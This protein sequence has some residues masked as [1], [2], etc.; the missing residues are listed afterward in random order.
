MIQDIIDTGLVQWGAVKVILGGDQPWTQRV[1]GVS[2]CPQVGSMF[3]EGIWSGQKK[4]WEGS[5]IPR[6]ME[7]DEAHYRAILLGRPFSQAVGC[8]TQRILKLPRAWVV[9]CI[10]HLTMAM[11]RS[12]GEF[13]DRKA[14]AVTPALRQDLQV[15]LSERR[16]GWSV[17]GAASPDREET[18]NFFEAWPRIARCLGIRPS[19]AKCKAITNLWDVLH[20]LY[21]TYQAPNP[22]NCAAVARDFWRHCTAGTASWY[23]LSLEHDVDAMLH[24][25]KPFRLAMFSGDIS[26]SINRFLKHGHNEHSNRGGGVLSGG[27]GGR[28][29]GSS[30]V[31][32][33]QGGQCASTVHDMAICIL[34]R[35]MGS[36][37]G[38]PVASAVLGQGCHGGEEALEPHAGFPRT[39]SSAS[40]TCPPRIRSGR[41]WDRYFVVRS[42]ADLG[43]R[44]SVDLGSTIR[45]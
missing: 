18:A 28:L 29:V 11:G 30:V 39:E 35:V 22:L 5:A 19:T 8:S 9:L 25:I 38:G 36:A 10:L 32:H 15:L 4:T 37:R 24:N 34:R 27:G 43:K 40:S 17:Y 44:S 31:R 26:E 14:R 1:I 2:T 20:A 33:P 45:R 41:S 13:V 12:L 21:C 42:S 6:T 16:A 23:L 3:N 7:S